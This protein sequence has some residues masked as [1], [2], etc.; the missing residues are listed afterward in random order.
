MRKAAAIFA[1]AALAAGAVAAGPCNVAEIPAAKPQARAE[2]RAAEMP[3]AAAETMP[4]A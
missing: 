1:L 4:P 2:V 3:S